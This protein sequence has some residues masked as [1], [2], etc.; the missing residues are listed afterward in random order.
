MRTLLFFI[1][2]S[3]SFSCTQKDRKKESPGL[4]VIYSA[5]IKDS[6]L[7]NIVKPESFALKD[8]ARVIFIADGGINL[9]HYVTAF[10]DTA[11]TAVSSNFVLVIIS[12]TG[13]WHM[14]RRRDFLPSDISGDSSSEFGKASAYYQFLAQEIIPLV[15]KEIPNQ[16]ETIFIGHSFSGLF[17]LYALLQNPQLF[18]RYYA[19]SPSCWANSNELSKIEEEFFRHHKKLPAKVNLYAGGLERLNMVLGSSSEF[20]QQIKSRNYPDLTISFDTVSGETHN[21]IIKP[22]L[23]KIF[24]DLNKQ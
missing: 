9:G 12:H 17:A 16:K 3:G 10:F 14:K 21:S 18:D 5:I 2:L 6:F 13:N 24:K 20:Y 11:K 7:F 1:L 19:I 8:S 23:S 22:V 4:Q 15:R